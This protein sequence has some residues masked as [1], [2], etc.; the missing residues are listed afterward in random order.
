MSYFDKDGN[1]RAELL[2]GEAEKIAKGFIRYREDTRRG[3]MQVDTR[4][5][6]TSAQLRRF[7]G[8]FKQLQK[9]VGAQGFNRVKPLIKMVKSKAAYSANPNNR[10]I[11]D[12]FRDFLLKNVDAI[13]D[14]R[15]FEA[16]MLHFEAVVGFFYGQGVS[17]N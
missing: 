16:F 5:S 7:Y 10:K 8:D 1:I 13:N 2:D 12:T 3:G 15:D 6:L 14:E 9:K 4:S 11:P 17:N